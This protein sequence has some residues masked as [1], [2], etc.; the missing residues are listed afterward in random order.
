MR[1]AITVNNFTVSFH[2]G[3]YPLW[4]SIVHEGKEV[5]R[6]H[7]KELK[8][9]EHCLVRIRDEVRAALPEK[10]EREA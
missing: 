6:V 4:V 10:E 7:H 5:L 8:D 9:L 2:D 1:R 3:G